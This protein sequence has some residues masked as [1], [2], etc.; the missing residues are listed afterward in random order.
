MFRIIA[1][2]IALVLSACANMTPEQKTVAWV[3]GGVA[4]TAIII[5]ASDHDVHISRPCKPTV[6]GSGADFDFRCRPID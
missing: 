1:I 3:V 5:S 4:A 6:G 2:C